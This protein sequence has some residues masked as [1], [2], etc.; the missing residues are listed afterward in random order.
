MKKH[1]II[2]TLISPNGDRD[3]I[4]PILMYATTGHI[5]KQRLDKEL[6]RRLGDLYQWEIAVQQ[7]ED[8]QL[9]LF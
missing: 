8:E 3:T 5:L 9:V 4:G 1:Q 6:Q 7:V 2:Y